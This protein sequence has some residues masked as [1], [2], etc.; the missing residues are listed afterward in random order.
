MSYPK[1][2]IGIL[3]MIYI[4][5]RLF[6]KIS[7][8][9]TE[10]SVNCLDQTVIASLNL[11][12]Q[13]N[14]SVMR[15][16]KAFYSRS[17]SALKER[18]DK[19]KE[20][21][22]ISAEYCNFLEKLKN[23]IIKEGGENFG[24]ESVKT[25]DLKGHKTKDNNDVVRRIMIREG[26]ASEVYQRKLKMQEDLTGIIKNEAWLDFKKFYYKVILPAE[27]NPY[28]ENRHWMNIVFRGLSIK[29]AL[30]FLT[31]LQLDARNIQLNIVELII[32]T[33]GTCNSSFDPYFILYQAEKTSLREGETLKASVFIGEIE[34]NSQIYIDGKQY[35]I[36]VGLATYEVIPRKKGIYKVPV[37][38]KYGP[39]N[40]ETG[41][42]IS[43]EVLEKEK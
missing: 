11:V 39:E 6:T 33:I 34:Y 20:C 19:V 40:K 21:D 5:F 32:N 3:V 43:Y 1:V 38:I 35:E 12:N 30:V 23:R 18:Y 14:I 24:N 41:T 10:K 26:I 28:I 29:S 31:K 37:T 15:N 13:E 27:G 22:R 42:V 25:L 17:P 9:E 2:F 7:E 16:M 8:E 36:E 4:P